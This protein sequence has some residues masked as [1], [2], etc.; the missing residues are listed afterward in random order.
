MC[1]LVVVKQ[2]STKQAS[3]HVEEA[4]ALERQQDPLGYRLHQ[5][6][7]QVLG[8]QEAT[9]RGHRRLKRHRQGLPQ[10]EYYEAPQSSNEVQ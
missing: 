10:T 8:E 4:R 2:T 7:A 6:V 3:I 5:G 1:S 9:R